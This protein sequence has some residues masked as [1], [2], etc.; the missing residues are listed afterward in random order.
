MRRFTPTRAFPLSFIQWLINN[1]NL[2][3]KGHKPYIYKDYEGTC[4]RR[5]RRHDP[6]VSKERDAAGDMHSLQ[7]Q[8]QRS[9][10]TSLASP[11]GEAR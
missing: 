1:D 8:A 4:T 3:I 9:D 6:C 5:K 10:G 11:S 2:V 7:L